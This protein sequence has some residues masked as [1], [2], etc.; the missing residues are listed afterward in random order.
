MVRTP[1]EP[2]PV[3]VEVEKV[4]TSGLPA[5]PMLLKTRP[6]RVLLPKRFSEDEPFR[7]T[8]LPALI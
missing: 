7:V 1:L 5:P 8:T 2:A 6:A 4:L 3:A